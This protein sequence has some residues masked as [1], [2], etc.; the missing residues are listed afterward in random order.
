MTTETTLNQTPLYDAHLKYGGKVIDFGGWALPVQYS[1]II[2]EH[3][4]VRNNAGLFDVSHMGE[5]MVEGKDAESYINYLVS[6]DVTKVKINQAQYSVL[7]YPDGVAVDDLL[8]YKLAEEKYLVVVNAS[9]TDK[10]F[11]WMQEHLKGDVT[12]SNISYEV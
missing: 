3:E 10:D 5:V 1:G 8:V 12:I 2:E 11:A 6:N 9:N 7:C 4:A